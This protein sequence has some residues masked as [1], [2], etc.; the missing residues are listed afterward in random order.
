MPLVIKRKMSSAAR[1]ERWILA[2]RVRYRVGVGFELL[3]SNHI[4]FV[5]GRFTGNI[6]LQKGVVDMSEHVSS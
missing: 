1:C 2:R 6:G 4:F 5:V 3:L